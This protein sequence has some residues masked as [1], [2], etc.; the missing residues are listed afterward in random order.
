MAIIIA[1]KI[2]AKFMGI[3]VVVLNEEKELKMFY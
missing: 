2:S 3:H 1:M